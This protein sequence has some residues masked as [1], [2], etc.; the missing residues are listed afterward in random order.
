[1]ESET[2]ILGYLEFVLGRSK[3]T[4]RNNHA[5]I[6]PNGCVSP[7]HKLEVNIADNKYNCWVCSGEK[8]GYKGKNLVNLFKQVKAPQHIIEEVKSLLNDTN[9]SIEW[10]DD[11]ITE[12]KQ[13]IQLPDEYKPLYPQPT[14]IIARHALVY[15]KKRRIL[16]D[17]IIKY[18]IGYC[19]SGKYKNRIIIPLY[20]DKGELIYFEAR[21]FDDNSLH[22]LKPDFPRDIIPNEH[23]INWNLP[24]ILCEGAFDMI[25][26]KRNVIPLLGKSI[27]NELM[28]KL[29]TSQVKKI[30]IVLDKDALKKAIQ[31]CE[32]LLQAEKEV[33]MVEMDNKDASKLGFQK[34]T[35]LIQ[36][37]QP[38][39][40]S[41]LLEYKLS[42]I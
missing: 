40:Y 30:Y 13:S 6:C 8:G 9:T 1:M 5:F 27:Q 12:V 35:E 42:K 36:T 29:V 19:S 39:T 7:K 33:Y 34:F 25:A 15:L 17:D 24:I 4:A 23:L 41:K 20:N 38:L 26:I 3:K 28:K 10:N 31:Y 22:Y 11:K 16:R 21:A 18:N 14:E 37:I 32:I 2:I